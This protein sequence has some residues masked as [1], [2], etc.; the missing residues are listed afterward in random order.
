MNRLH[1]KYKATMPALACTDMLASGYHNQI[2][3]TTT[4]TTTVIVFMSP[5]SSLV[6]MFWF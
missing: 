6:A 1:R 3:G 2:Y 4:T 5:S